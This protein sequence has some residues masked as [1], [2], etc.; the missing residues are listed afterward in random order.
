[1]DRRPNFI[2]I[3]SDQMRADCLGINGQRGGMY[4]PNLDSMAYQGARFTSAYSTCPICIPQRLSLLTGQKAEHHGIMDNLGIPYL[5]LETTLP[6]EMGR[7]GYQTALVGRTMHT[8]PFTHPYGFEYYMPGDLTSDRKDADPFYRFLR[9]ELPRDAADYMANGT[10]LNSRV[11][12]PFQL[13]D[14]FHHSTWTTNRALEF[15]DTRDPSRPFMLFVGYMAPHSPFNP[16]SEYFHRY[17]DRNHIDAPYIADYDVRP[18]SNGGVT[19][20]YAELKDEELRTLQAGYYGGITHMD[21]QIGRLLDRLVWMPN[22][23]V[24]FTSDHG[25]MLGDH[26]SMHKARSWQG[27]VHIPLLI[28]GPGI[29]GNQAFDQPVGWHD[30]MPTVL[31]LAGLPVPDSVDGE[32]LADLLRGGNPG[33]L[34]RVIHGECS[35]LNYARYGGYEAQDH[36]GNIMDESGSHYVTDGKWKLIWYPGSGR[37]QLFHLETDYGELHDLSS[38][39]ACGEV[40]EELRRELMAELSGRPEG[41]VA[42]GALVS[43]TRS[44][45]LQPHAQALYETR[46]KEFLP[47]AYDRPAFFPDARDYRNTLR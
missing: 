25:E 39:P 35:H 19:S 22:T 21:V 1:M 16:P 13:E 46:R 20:C 28:Y 24:I 27:A 40:L 29:R 6:T 14:R 26:Y 18:V 15:L 32:N 41:F 31:G 36:K 8:Y 5:P 4:T 17:Y 42:D 9:E 45:R 34:R 2:I 30:I 23:Y 43:G 7:G 33:N 44:L 37:E 11:A 3:H 38:D 12:A 10:A 47:I